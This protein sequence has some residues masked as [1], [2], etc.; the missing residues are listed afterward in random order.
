MSSFLRGTKHRFLLLGMVG[1]LF[2]GG[3][4][5]GN[6]PRLPVT[7]MLVELGGKVVD[8]RTGEGVSGARIVVRDYPDRTGLS[9]SD[10]SF[11]IPRVPSGKQVLVVT[12][13]GYASKSQAVTVPN[14]GAFAVIIELVPFLGKL[15]GFVW[16]EDGKPVAGA[17]VTVDAQYIVFTQE[18]GG[19]TLSSLPVG[20]FVLTVEKEGLLPYS[21]EV[22]IQASGITVVKVVLKK[23]AP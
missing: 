17:T 4:F 19:F 23:P 8:A 12:A 11:F 7:S 20:K 9:A 5:L 18:N 6:A 2:L 22:E 21:G 16:D 13:Y 15:T 14:S 3:C 10:G 1:V